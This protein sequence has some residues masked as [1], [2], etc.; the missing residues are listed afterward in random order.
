MLSEKDSMSHALLNSGKEKVVH[1]AD[2][3]ADKVK[4]SILSIII[5][6]KYLDEVIKFQKDNSNNSDNKLPKVS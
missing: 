2:K 5:E 3:I 4:G 6:D 1:I